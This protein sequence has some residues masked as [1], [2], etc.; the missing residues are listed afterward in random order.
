MI[1]SR[2][3]CR[4]GRPCLRPFGHAAR[5][6]FADDGPVL[7]DVVTMSNALEVPSHM[8]ADARGSALSPGKMVLAAGGGEVASLLGPTSALVRGPSGR[9]LV[10]CPLKSHVRSLSLV[11]R[12]DVHVRPATSGPGAELRS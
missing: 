9:Q 6:V 12:S 5:K 1:C 7:L 11:L 8:S 10:G 2:F 4:R 3:W